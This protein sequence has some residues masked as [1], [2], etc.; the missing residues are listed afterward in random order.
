MKAAVASIVMVLLCSCVAFGDV[1]PDPG[2]K[3]ISMKLIVETKEDLD[4]YR[5]FIKSGSDIRE[6]FIKP[7]SLASVS[8]LGGGAFYSVGKLL[9]VPKKGLTGFSE[10]A[11]EK[12]LNE[13]QQAVY[14][15][16]VDG[17]IE[18]L[19]HSFSHEV[20]E[21]DVDKISDVA[22]RIDR[23]L[24]IGLRAV[25]VSGGVNP[26]IAEAP[27]SSGRLFWQGAGAAIVAALFLAFGITILG[28]LYFRKRAKEL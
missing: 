7:G 20:A 2:F 16:K 5:F 11:D 27:Q 3:R 25:Y 22:Y 9:A 10:A 23:D 19:N 14:D 12:K 4:D 8:P 13:L 21:G 15:G 6:I 1:A 18:L 28:V 26:K 24:Q 17:M